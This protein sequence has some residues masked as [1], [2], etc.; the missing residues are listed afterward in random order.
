VEWR[1]A[2]S[3][4]SPT[5]VVTAG[6]RLETALAAG[7]RCAGSWGGFGRFVMAVSLWDLVWTGVGP[8]RALS[9]GASRR[10]AP[11]LFSAKQLRVFLVSCHWREGAG[12]VSVSM[13]V[14]R[15][16]ALTGAAVG[17]VVTPP[18]GDAM[19]TADRRPVAADTGTTRDTCAGGCA[20]TGDALCL[21]DEER[22]A[23]VD[24]AP[25][26]A[27]WAHGQDVSAPTLR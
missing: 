5:R 3:S 8:L 23:P 16:T 21:G 11:A 22:G 7:G 10:G 18:V 14:E 9:L 13:L 27:A 24:V 26:R 12:C 25:A 6:R 17:W 1:G 2:A 19:G 20:S 4:P 15:C